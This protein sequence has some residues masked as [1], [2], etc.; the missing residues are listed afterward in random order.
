[1]RMTLHFNKI[2]CCAGEKQ[3]Q[4]YSLVW[5]K[6]HN[7]IIIITKEKKLA[8]IIVTTASQVWL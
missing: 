5:L 6:Y 7:N 4:G 8:L 3:H 1:M 2:Y